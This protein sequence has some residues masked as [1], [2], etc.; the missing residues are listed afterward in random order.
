MSRFEHMEEMV[1]QQ[2]KR[3]RVAFDLPT[4][5][6]LDRLTHMRA[7]GQPSYWRIEIME[8]GHGRVVIGEGETI[9][10]A[11]NHAAEKTK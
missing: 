8:I 7:L 2:A 5:W 10:K 3:T 9:A 1:A 4:G 6:T 11:V